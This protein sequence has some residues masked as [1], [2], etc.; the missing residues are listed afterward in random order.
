M[1]TI[2]WMWLK[3]TLSKGAAVLVALAQHKRASLSIAMVLDGGRYG[4]SRESPLVEV[5]ISNWST[6]RLPD[7][8]LPD[9]TTLRSPLTLRRACLVLEDIGRYFIDAVAGRKMSNINSPM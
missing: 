6:A 7:I 4:S 2:L 5:V 8:C 1:N 9:T 3:A